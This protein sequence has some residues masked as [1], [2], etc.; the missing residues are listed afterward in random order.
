MEKQILNIY[1]T[2]D[3]HLSEIDRRIA[4]RSQGYAK[5]ALSGGL[6]N[7]IGYIKI[8]KLQKEKSHDSTRT[9]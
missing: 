4:A 1:N 5:Y 7:P 8:K 2:T 3:T 9:S 6:L